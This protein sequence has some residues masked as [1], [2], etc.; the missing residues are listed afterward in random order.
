MLGLLLTLLKFLSI[1][2][3]AFFGIAGLLHDFKDNN[4]R[5][6]KWGR[7]SLAGILLSGMIAG[8]TEI[9]L[10]F[11]SRAQEAAEASRQKEVLNRIDRT[12][13]QSKNI[14]QET[15][16]VLHPIEDLHGV[17]IRA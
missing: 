8:A 9:A 14:L 12:T 17:L 6:T 7:I 15:T 2:A 3:T 13:A 4:D 1:I 5:I 10:I 11:K 16:R